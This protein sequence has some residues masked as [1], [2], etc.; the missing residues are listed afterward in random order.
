M[1]GHLPA[2]RVVSLES[3]NVLKPFWVT[4]IAFFYAGPCFLSSPEEFLINRAKAGHKFSTKVNVGYK[5]F[6][7]GVMREAQSVIL[8]SLQLPHL[9]VACQM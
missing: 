7:M 9:V 3:E 8:D 4:S 5:I 1:Q 2:G 6:P